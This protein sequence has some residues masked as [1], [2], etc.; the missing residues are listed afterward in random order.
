[1]FQF[2]LGIPWELENDPETIEYFK[3]RIPEHAH[4]SAFGI[5]ECNFQRLKKQQKRGGN[6]RVD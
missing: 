2:C 3:T 6:V 4:W 5:E 1:M